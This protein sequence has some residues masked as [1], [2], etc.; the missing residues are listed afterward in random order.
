[1]KNYID[2]ILIIGLQISIFYYLHMIYNEKLKTIEVKAEFP[3]VKVIPGDAGYEMKNNFFYDAGTND[4][5][6]YEFMEIIK[7]YVSEVCPEIK[8]VDLN[9]EYQKKWKG[10]AETKMENLN[11]EQPGLVK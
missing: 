6:T 9:A 5:R 11:S 1:M 2:S 10:V 4:V 3:M 7:K 8:I